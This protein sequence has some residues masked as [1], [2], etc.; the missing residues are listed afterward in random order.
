MSILRVSAFERRVGGRER[1]GEGRR[2]EKGR[3][4]ERRQDERG[5]EEHWRGVGGERER[6]LTLR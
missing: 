5:R 4:E 1:E 3:R 6:I 2:G